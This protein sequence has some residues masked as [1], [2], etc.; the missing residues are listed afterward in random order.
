[1]QPYPHLMHFSI[2]NYIY[3]YKASYCLPQNLFTWFYAF[4]QQ[5]KQI[6]AQNKDPLKIIVE[7]MNGIY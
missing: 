3:T 7:P 4:I 5:I 6:I 2:V 1:M